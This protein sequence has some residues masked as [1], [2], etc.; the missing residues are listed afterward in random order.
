[1]FRYNL[2]CAKIRRILGIRQQVSLVK[3]GVFGH[4]VAIYGFIFLHDFR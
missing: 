2:A 1:M 4:S 3:M